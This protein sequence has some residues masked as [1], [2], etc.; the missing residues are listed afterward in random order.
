MKE[1]KN[2]KSQ[3]P[4]R[5]G[6]IGAGFGSKVHI[7]GFGK[8]KGV[9]IIALSGR[10]ET[11]GKQIAN[12][13]KIPL[14][15]TDWKKIV[16]NPNVDAV[17]IAVPP[18]FQKKIAVFAAR[19]GKHIFCEKPLATS[20]KEAREIVLAV[21]KAKVIGAIDLEFR[22]MPGLATLKKNIDEGKIGRVRR[23]NIYWLTG[24]RASNVA[25]L[26]WQNEKESGGGALFSFAS[27]V[28]DYVEMLFGKMRSVSAHLGTI[29]K[30]GS[31]AEDSCD[32][33]FNSSGNFPVNISISNVIYGGRGHGIEVY[34]ERGTLKLVNNNPGDPMSE[35]KLSHVGEDGQKETFLKIPR[36]KIRSGLDSRLS[37]FLPVAENFINSIRNHK[38]NARPSLE[39]GLR[40]QILL[41]AAERS[42]RL[43]RV[44]SIPN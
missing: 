12:N 1:S 7:P 8:I 3:K 39:E 21:K 32:I 6:V 9:K 25:S 19:Q 16:A 41:E 27:H 31:T 29:K 10:S 40:L 11:K 22:N 37:M 38:K 33:M 30:N 34:G 24:G 44:I 23:A 13:L 43:G 5:I 28:V 35:F 15:S 36:T 2:K 4:I 26:G 14:F 18:I 20:V 42:N 17:S